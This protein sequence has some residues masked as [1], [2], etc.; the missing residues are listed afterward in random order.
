VFVSDLVADLPPQFA[1]DFDNDGDV[2]GQDLIAWRAGFGM[3]GAAGR[4]DGDADNDLDVDGHDFLIWQQE[5]GS[6]SAAAATSPIPE[7][8]TLALLLYSSLAV[9]ATRRRPRS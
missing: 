6:T 7:P 2:D 9:F 3:A 1:A 4:A 8:A 5:L